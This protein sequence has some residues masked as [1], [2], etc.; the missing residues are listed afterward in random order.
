MGQNNTQSER[1][2][3]SYLREKCCY[4]RK[5]KTAEN[6]KIRSPWA[7]WATVQITTIAVLFCELIFGLCIQREDVTDQQSG[8]TFVSHEWELMWN[9]TCSSAKGLV[10]GCSARGGLP[11]RFVTKI[12][13]TNQIIQ[14]LIRQK[15][16]KKDQLH[17]YS[18]ASEKLPLPH[19]GKKGGEVQHALVWTG[20]SEILCTCAETK[21]ICEI[22]AL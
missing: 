6:G 16:K 12:T 17:V 18:S 14:F 2:N 4:C 9:P 10:W 22:T 8:N 19:N 7:W 11:E 5:R 3:V 1:R 15:K 20:S 21:M 13:F